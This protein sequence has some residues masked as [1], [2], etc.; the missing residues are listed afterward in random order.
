MS[1]RNGGVAPPSPS[2]DPE[3]G[4]VLP[5]PGGF[6]AHAHLDIVGL[7]VDGV[8]GAARAA[9][10]GRVVNVG[11]DLPSSRWSVAAAQE[12]AGLYA[13]VAIHP[14]DTAKVNDHRA[15]VL[16]ELAVLAASPAVVAI[17]ETGL[18]YYRDWSPPSVQREWFRAHIELARA[19]GKA[20]M[21]HDR[22][23]HDDVLSILDEYAPWPPFSVIFHCFSGDAAMAARCAEAGYLMS[24]AGNVTF[25]NADALREAARVAPPELMLAET[26]APYLTPVPHRGKPNSP[27]MTAYTIRFLAA[28]KNLDIADFCARLQSTGAQVFGW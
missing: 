23:A 3:G 2:A 12:H 22:D 14:N 7:P 18:D 10:I 1:E 5:E 26:D 9:G 20:V 6:D 19:A 11:C 25:K 17:G 27:A 24:F 8:L 4:G 16:A 13:A 28:L 15:E 21:I